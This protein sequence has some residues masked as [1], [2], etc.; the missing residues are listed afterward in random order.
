MRVLEGDFEL[1]ILSLFQRVQEV[2]RKPSCEP[3][4][5]G[6]AFKDPCRHGGRA[7]LGMGPSSPD[8]APSRQQH[9]LPSGLHCCD[10]PT[11]DLSFHV[12]ELGAR[13]L[14]G[15]LQGSH[16]TRKDGMSLEQ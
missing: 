16:L 1:L 10:S 12:R 6:G 5:G 13:P 14:A 3:N 8:Y 11:P 7:E 4:W 9:P 15:H 2:L